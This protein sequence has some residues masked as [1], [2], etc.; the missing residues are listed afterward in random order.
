M[1]SIRKNIV[2]VLN[3]NDWEETKRYCEV[4]KNFPSVD[5]IVVVDNKSTDNSIEEL[6]RISS[7]KVVIIE[8]T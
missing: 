5:Q 8:A 1:A 2:V 6:K 4:V 7:T 3:Y